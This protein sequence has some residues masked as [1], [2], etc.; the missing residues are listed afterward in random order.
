MKCPICGM[1]DPKHR[2]RIF[3][4]CTNCQLD[5]V[6]PFHQAESYQVGTA[7]SSVTDAGYLQMMKQY[8]THREKLAR[9]MAKRRLEEYIKILGKKPVSICE[10]GAGDGAF[11]T[12]YK[13]LGIDY[14]GVDINPD[15]VSQA[16]SLGRNVLLGEPDIL[17]SKY[18]V[19]VFSQVLE[20]ILEP[21]D[22]MRKVRNLS[23]GIIHIDVP[24]RNGLVSKLRILKPTNT[25]WG[26]LQFPHHQLAYSEK[27]LRY[28]LSLTSLDVIQMSAKGNFDKTWGQLSA[29]VPMHKRIAL[30]LSGFLGLSSL[31]VCIARKAN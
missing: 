23:R 18:D 30:E 4:T 17:Q 15:L 26:F 8:A 14:V 7:K 24:N 2:G 12:P 9:P 13:E 10:V 25:E 11:A 29:N 19:I 31:L 28:L 21:I 6:F 27:S 22:F 20:H 3:Y 1:G 16:Q 5:F